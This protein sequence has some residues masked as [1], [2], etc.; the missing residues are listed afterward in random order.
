[1]RSGDPAYAQARL[2]GAACAITPGELG[3]GVVEPPDESDAKNGYKTFSHGDAGV[4]VI[5][6]KTGIIEWFAGYFHDPGR[7]ES[8]PE[9]VE[10][11]TA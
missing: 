2:I 1:M 5:D 6:S 7:Q 8:G 10:L 4:G 3:V 9:R 11:A